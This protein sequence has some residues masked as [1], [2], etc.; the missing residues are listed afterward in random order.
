M[1]TL[2]NLV[3]EVLKGLKRCEAVG[4]AMGCKQI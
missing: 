4:L 2:V 3:K 1:R